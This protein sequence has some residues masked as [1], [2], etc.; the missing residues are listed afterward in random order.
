MNCLDLSYHHHVKNMINT[1]KSAQQMMISNSQKHINN[2]DSACNSLHAVWDKQHFLQKQASLF[3]EPEKFPITT[4]D[5]FKSTPE[6]SVLIEPKDEYWSS[7]LFLG[8]AKG[9]AI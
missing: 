1:Y 6:V 9:K 5:E 8:A 7:F 4:N 2:M 3:E